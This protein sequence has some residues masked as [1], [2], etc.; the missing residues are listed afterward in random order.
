MHFGLL[1]F[2]IIIFSNGFSFA[3][4]NIFDV[5]RFGSVSDI[6][7][8]IKI[9]PDTINSIN[10]T[11]YLPITL[12]CYSGSEEVAIYL[13]KRTKNINHNDSNG[14][15]LMAAVFKNRPAIVKV[16]LEKGANPNLADSNGTTPLHYAV[17]SENYDL[18]KMLIGYNADK[19]K[20]NNK[21]KSAFDYALISKNKKIITIF[22]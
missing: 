3:Q 2:I 16:L 15:A 4:R 13:A 5:A 19:Y 14:T 12:A 11:G 18:V 10:E 17:M 20:M 22:D 8:L 6:E 21:G 9:N 1:T 7:V